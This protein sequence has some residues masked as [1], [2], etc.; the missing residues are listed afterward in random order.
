[1]KLNVVLL[2]ILLWRSSLIVAFLSPF[3]Q[4]S[5]A[6]T[7]RLVLLFAKDKKDKDEYNKSKRQGHDSFNNNSNNNDAR[8]FAT[9]NELKLIRD[10][11]RNLYESLQWAEAM[12]DEE[13]VQGLI[14]LIES[15]ERRDPERVFAQTRV[16]IARVQST[17]DCDPIEKQLQIHK[18]KQ[19]AER[20]RSQL[21]RFQMEGLWVGAYV[22][23]IYACVFLSHFPVRNSLPLVLRFRYGANDW[24]LV[25]ITYRG[26]TLVA[27]K[28]TGD[29][30]VPRGQTSFTADLSPSLSFNATTSRCP[31]QGQIA[32]SGFVHHQYVKGH[33][34]LNDDCIYHAC[35]SYDRFSFVWYAEQQHTV[36]FQRPTPQQTLNL[37]RNTLSREDEMENMR[38]HLIECWDLDAT[39][40]LARQHA[41]KLDDDDDDTN[42]NGSF[43]RI[44]FLEELEK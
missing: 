2:F 44:R 40:A 30:N 38:T 31:G 20:V 12:H 1:M 4:N 33:L 32:Q 34:F 21:P 24:Q 41:G 37:L 23:C 14:Q 6:T 15:H 7:R 13:R 17:F 42:E 26:D 16:E 28:T 39:D 43:R 8:I 25:N 3:C 9:G 35:C 29:T 10:E 36:V 22:S 11:L 19:E 27:T 18:L 5:L